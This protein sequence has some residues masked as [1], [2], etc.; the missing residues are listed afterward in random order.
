MEPI[1]EM[2]DLSKRYDDFQLEPINLSMPKGYIMGFV[3]PNGSGKSTTIKLMLNLIK[4]DSGQVKI[5]G[6]DSV[7]DEIAI[8]QRIGFVLDD[9]FF[10]EGMTIKE[11]E[12]FVSGFYKEWD[13]KQFNEY[14][15][16]FKLPLKKKIKELSTGMKAKLSLAIALS[17]HA[18][19]LILDEPTSGLDPIV[20]DDILT[21]LFAVIKDEECGVFFSS[22]ITSDIEKVADYIT[23]IHDGKI[24]F[25]E[26]KEA[27]LETY[28]VIK[29]SKQMLNDV[30]DYIISYRQ[31]EFGFD[32][33]TTQ[34]AN[35]RKLGLDRLI[36]EK[37]TI[38]DIML[39][40]IKGESRGV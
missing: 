4:K 15:K 12:W 14:L 39:Y 24:V 16:K 1:F 25:A 19:L 2:I 8:K 26:T 40:H 21:E 27:I 37:A 33:L 3:G 32:A 9:T 38:D 11:V 35:L 6:L 23:F 18:K 7:E 13:V 20:R 29:G 5:F 28:H 31:S 34:A 36:I 30:K 22:H 17:H 10:H